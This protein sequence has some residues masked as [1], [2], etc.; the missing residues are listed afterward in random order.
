MGIII[1]LLFKKYGEIAG[2]IDLAQDRIEWQTSVNMV[3][4]F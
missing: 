1:K 3:M 2:W 4:D